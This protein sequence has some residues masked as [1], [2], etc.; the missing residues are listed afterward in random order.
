MAPTTPDRRTVAKK[1]RFRRSRRSKSKISNYSPDVASTFLIQAQTYLQQSNLEN[2]LSTTQKALRC[3]T[4]PT[5]P[6]PCLEQL[7]ALE[8]LGAIHIELGDA[9][10]A[11][12]SFQQAAQVDPDGEYAGAEKF[13]WLAQLSED[14]G[15]DTIH[16]FE[17]GIA[18]LKKQLETLSNTSEQSAR[19]GM[20]EE[21]VEGDDTAVED[22]E[23]ETADTVKEKLASALC[24]AAEV[25]MT[26][27][28][29]E[30]DCEAKCE[31]F[32]NDAVQVAPDSPSVLQ[33]L[34]N[35]RI[36]QDRVEEAKEALRKSMDSWWRDNDG[37][38]EGNNGGDD[39][40]G[41]LYTMEDVPDFPTR[42]SLVRLLME[43]DMCERAMKIL[44]RLVRED[45]CSVEAWYLGGWCQHLLS[46]ET[47]AE[48]DSNAEELLGESSRW[49]TCCLDNFKSQDYEDDRLRDHAIELLKDLDSKLGPVPSEEG[50]EGDNA[51]QDL[52][53]GDGDEV[54]NVID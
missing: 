6:T 2:A 29:F 41:Q 24:G 17:K 10:E 44:Q 16:W 14:G 52:E 5:Q 8:I 54:M 25:Y 45:D 11:R 28:S 50:K 3:L 18:C 1:R 22:V 23:A 9:A 53:D 4:P 12:R 43:V 19:D 15:L 13:M 47:Q 32:V 20:Q 51:W 39:Q 42:I 40:E 35:V 31:A 30:D 37:D 36:S 21:D 34:A 38:A 7:P 27:L 33:T 46:S 49:L 48:S 26:D